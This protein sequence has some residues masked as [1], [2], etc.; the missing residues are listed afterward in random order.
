[1]RVSERAH[2][3]SAVALLALVGG[4]VVAPTRPVVAQGDSA[5]VDSAQVSYRTTDIVFFSA[6]RAEGVRVGDTVSV[7]GDG[8]SV[9]ARAVVLSAAPHTASARLLGTDVPVAVGQR[10]RFDARLA[11]EAADSLAATRDSTPALRGDTAQGADSAARAEAPPPPRGRWVRPDPRARGGIQIEEIGSSTGSTGA[12]TSYQTVGSVFLMAPLLSGVELRTRIS[13]RW[14]SGAAARTTGLDGFRA[15]PY[16]LQLRLGPAEGAWSASL[17]R[18]VP[19]EA[20]GLGYLDGARLEVRLGSQQRLGVVAGFVPEVAN[21]SVSTATKRGGVYLAF[22]GSGALAGSLSAAADWSAG[23]RRRTL[24][25]SQT[26]WR[27]LDHLWLSASA[28]VDIGSPSMTVHGLQLTNGYA[29]LRMDLPLGFR[30][31][32]G[33]ESHQAILLWESVQAG[34]STP[35][36]GR[37]NGLS[38]SLG[39]DILGFR[40]D[41]SGGALKRSTDPAP[42]YRGMLS[43]SHGLFFLVASGQHGDLFDYGTIMARL[44]L[45][46]RALP[47]TASLGASASVTRSAGG[48]VSQW[49]YSIQPE[50][51]RSLGGGLFMSLGGDIGT[52]AGRTTTFVHAGVS[53]RFR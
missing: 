41:L 6:G 8:G 11:T 22:G 4:L 38:A 24:V 26:Y 27:L 48:A 51:S 32:V 15:I 9:L 49:R 31:S 7:V 29:N 17:G 45:P 1:M 30:G 23:A 16:E 19:T 44:M 10:V 47:V 35:L 28:E 37:L 2:R 34:D 46:Y 21:L 36:A 40:V 53:Y 18:F 50:L 13:G 33:V 12:L 20:P 5:R 39:R 14:R 52:Y 42:T 43:L 3:P 25:A